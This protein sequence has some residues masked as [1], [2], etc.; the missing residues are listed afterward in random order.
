M[1][2]ARPLY[3]LLLSALLT[4]L[5]ITGARS[6]AQEKPKLK[7]FGSSLKKLTW[8]PTLDQAVLS[9]SKSKS[10]SNTK[11][12]DDDVVRVET[13]LV[14]TDLLVLDAHG[15]VVSGLTEKDFA[16]SEDGR[17]Q[18][19]GMFSLGDNVALPRSVVLIIDYSASQFP[20]IHTSIEAAKAMVDK[21]PAGDHLAIVTDDVEL[22]QDFTN[23]KK[24]LKKKLDSLLKRTAY[25]S[26]GISEHRHFGRSWQ[27][28]ALMAT[29]NE[30]FNNED[31]RP[32]VIFQ[33]DG[34]ELAELRNPPAHPLP[35]P[36]IE[37]KL[38]PAVLKRMKAK[39]PNFSLDDLCR[40][41]ERARVTIYSIV[42]G[43]QYFGLP[44][45]EQRK[46]HLIMW[47]EY[48]EAISRAGLPGS[49]DAQRQIEQEPAPEVLKYGIDSLVWSQSALSVVATA[50]GGATMFLE[51]SSQADEIYSRI[52]SD[53]NRRYLI[54]YYPTNKDHDGQRRK[55]NIEVR[56]HPDYTI[57][58][59]RGY[60][61]PRPD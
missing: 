45:E 1:H 21:L 12:T 8:D 42:S 30:A 11:A 3:P 48:W 2:T 26:F 32:I 27:Y 25:H 28:S 24:I 20:Y 51:N 56:G 23:D 10:K 17:P 34:D 41:A 22:I 49:E 61:A 33:T 35:P 39:P 44:P 52:F 13:S 31:Q 19:V 55:I 43:I 46:R 59:R 53:I 54:G 60:Y 6:Q 50:T 38:P 18:K 9:K 47:K 37:Y 29:L 14:V 57:V 36:G 58:C 15:N 5:I 4:L 16:I 40:A 7:D